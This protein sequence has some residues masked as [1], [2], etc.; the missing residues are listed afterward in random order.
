MVVH[1]YLEERARS[2]EVIRNKI[3]LM[4]RRL[5]AFSPDLDTSFWARVAQ[6]G[7]DVEPYT[8]E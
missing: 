8:I 2:D 3:D 1:H 5:E 7:R 6:I 4:K